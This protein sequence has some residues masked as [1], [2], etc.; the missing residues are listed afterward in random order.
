VFEKV[1]AILWL[2]SLSVLSLRVFS[3]KIIRAIAR[4]FA[5]TGFEAILKMALLDT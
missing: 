5:R 2:K 3:K 1:K 4:T